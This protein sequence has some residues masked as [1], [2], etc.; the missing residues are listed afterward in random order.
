[1]NYI[2]LMS[3]DY[4]AKA[5]R[6]RNQWSL[7]MNSKFDQL[8]AIADKLRTKEGSVRYNANGVQNSISRGI[9]NQTD[10]LSLCPAT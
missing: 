6:C 1:M 7:P 5:N 10:K 9:Q 2:W 4:L 8:Y 3:P